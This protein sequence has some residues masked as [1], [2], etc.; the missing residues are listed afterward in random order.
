MSEL[1]LEVHQRKREDG[2]VTFSASLCGDGSQRDTIWYRLPEEH[3]A[4]VTESA[5]PFIVG[6]LFRIMELGRKV[7][8]HGQASPVL[9]EGIEEFMA[10]WHAWRPER[11]RSVRI[12]A[13][14]EREPALQAEPGLAV[15]A[16]SGGLDSC[17]TLRRHHTGVVGR[18]R[19]NVVAGAFIHGHDIPLDDRRHFEACR[20][21]NRRILDSVG[22]ELIPVATNLRETTSAANH[23]GLAA[24][25]LS[26]L[27]LLQGRFDAGLIASSDPYESLILPTATSPLTDPL[28]STGRFGIL[29]DGAEF[30]RAEKAERIADW[31]EAMRDLRVC[32]RG[33]ETTANCGVCEKCV[34]TIL[35]FRA[36]GHGP[37]ECFPADVADGQIR[38]VRLRRL[39]EYSEWRSL[40]RYAREKGLGER[41]WVREVERALTRQRRQRRRKARRAGW[42]RAL[43]RLGGR[44]PQAERAS[45]SRSR[46]RIADGD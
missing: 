34:R 38:S 40:L 32:G 25:M 23:D 29:H 36:A 24:G 37:P 4:A 42:R 8:V 17:F 14:F 43:A 11:Y 7:Q 6:L 12:E 10:A 39:G 16:F 15:M 5:D 30:K 18:R 45:P 27:V 9:L 1:H 46:R 22:A 31:P 3:E 41:S 13:E 26:C 21:G 28:L 33:S 19:R 35:S 44:R 2:W 20:D